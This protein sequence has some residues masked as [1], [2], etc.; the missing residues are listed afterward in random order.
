MLSPRPREPGHGT[1]RAAWVARARSI[2]HVRRGECGR[3]PCGDP[4]GVARH[5]LR[6]RSLRPGAVGVCGTRAR[7]GAAA[8]M[9][10]RGR[11]A[12]GA[13]PCASG[14]HSHAFAMEHSPSLLLY[15]EGLHLVAAVLGSEVCCRCLSWYATPRR[16]PQPRR[17]GASQS[18]PRFASPPS[19]EPPASRAGCSAEAWP[20]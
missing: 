20:G 16:S 11:G 5:E 7:D 9:A 13:R 12:G 15:A 4:N 6:P 18:S 3:R 17:W 8:A 10:L 19:R 1:I 14:P 2:R